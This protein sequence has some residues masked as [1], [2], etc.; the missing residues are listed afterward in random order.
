MDWICDRGCNS[1]RGLRTRQ[2]TLQITKA[3]E[4]LCIQLNRRVM[5]ISAIGRISF[6]KVSDDVDY[7]EVLDLSRFTQS[8]YV[9]QWRCSTLEF[10]D[11]DK[12][13]RS[14]RNLRYRL[15]G[16]AAH[17][18]GASGGHYIAA[19]RGRSD[20]TPTFVQDF[21]TISDQHLRSVTHN[22][23]DRRHLSNHGTAF[24]PTLLFYVKQ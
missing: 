14:R 16:V 9:C 1:T 7:P 4:V 23:N 22:F 19:V 6:N 15:Y 8:G 21:M 10:N 20:G 12:H 5:K 11:A 3:P 13:D 17:S 24:D 18:G 2:R